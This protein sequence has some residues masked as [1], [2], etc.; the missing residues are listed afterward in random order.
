MHLL[1]GFS[2][3]TLCVYT[4]IP[5]PGCKLQQ[6]GSHL[7][8]VICNL[9]S[10]VLNN[11]LSSERLHHQIFPNMACHCSVFLLYLPAV[12]TCG[13]F[14]IPVHC[15]LS[16][17]ACPCQLLFRISYETISHLYSQRLKTVPGIDRC[18]LSFR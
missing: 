4:A 2:W 17:L 8:C 7:F 6:R 14:W 12:L 1:L 18:S 3:N 5:Y 10:T 11:Y 15:G 9:L 13:H 16:I